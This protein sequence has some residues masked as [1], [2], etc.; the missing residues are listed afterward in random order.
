MSGP[1][2]QPRVSVVVP[3]ISI[4]GYLEEAI[5]SLLQQEGCVVEVVVVLDGVEPSGDLPRWLED[6]RV[7][8]VRLPTRQG[9]PRALNHGIGRASGQ[10]IA[11]LDADDI[12]LPGRLRRQ[13]EFLDEHPEVVC[14]GTDFVLI[15]PASQVIGASPRVPAGAD[16]ARAL[17]LRNQLLH[18]SV[19]YRA[20]VV[21]AVGGYADAMHRMQDYELYLRLALHGGIAVLGEVLTAYRVHPG[22]HSRNTSPW[23]PY[24]RLLLRRRTELALALGVSRASQWARNALWFGAQVARHHGVVRPGYLRRPAGRAVSAAPAVGGHGCPSA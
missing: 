9:T 3:T 19:M 16:Q 2:P 18:S 13:V 11:R 6:G 8:V 12:A 20:D 10:L 7:R 1:R 22:Q 21:R 24:T 15:D 14:V 23:Q 4:D 17:L 5:E